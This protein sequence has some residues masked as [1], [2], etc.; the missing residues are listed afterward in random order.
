MPLAPL[1]RTLKDK[2]EW[3]YKWVGVGVWKKM[4]MKNKL[5][6]YLAES[7][8]DLKDSFHLNSLWAYS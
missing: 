8:F 3:N 4:K 1:L 2:R 6:T 7:T 5:E